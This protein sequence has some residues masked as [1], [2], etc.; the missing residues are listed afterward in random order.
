MAELSKG[1]ARGGEFELV[2]ADLVLSTGRVVGLK[3]SIINLTLFEDIFQYTLTGQI[4][5]QD[6]MSLASTGP[7]IGQE[8]LKLKLKTP[9]VGEPDRIIDY[10]ENAFM[11]TSLDLREPT[12]GGSQVSILSFCSREFAMNQRSVVNRTLTGSYSDIVERMLR[13]DLDSHKTFYKEP[14][15]ESKKI[16][17][18]NIDP[19]SVISIAES[20]ALS[21]KHSD[22]TY[23]FFENLRGFNFRTL[24]HLYSRTPMLNYSQYPAGQKTNRKGS[25]DIMKNIQNLEEYTISSSPDT[26]YNHSAGVYASHMIVHDIFSKS[27]ENYT[28]NYIDNFFNERHVDSFGSKPIFPLANV[29]PINPAGDDIADHPA[30]QYLQPTTGKSFDNSVQDNSSQTPFTPHNPQRSMQIRNAH[31]QMMNTALQVNID[32]LGT[33]V[34]AAGDIVECNIPF[35]GTYTTTQNEVFDRLYKGRFLIKAIRHDF[36]PAENQH[37][38]SM[39]LCKDNFLEP[40]EA[41]EE[42]YEPKSKRSKGTVTETWDDIGF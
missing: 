29:L 2:Q 7:I 30:K 5:I 17:A 42:N 31:M 32:V 28:Y 40:L 18:P 25:I 37:T 21:K 22:P 16:I 10:S 1:V 39:N 27:Y 26:I 9:T 23:L 12:S 38:M 35:S 6:A 4:V 19:F 8:Y 14:S 33:T 36:N 3:A 34:I 20:R 15:A 41:P 13:K 11:V 24:G